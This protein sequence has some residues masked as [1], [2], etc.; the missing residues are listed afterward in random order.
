[1]STSGSEDTE[2]DR[3][4]GRSGLGMELQISRGQKKKKKGL[5]YQ[6]TGLPREESHWKVC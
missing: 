4:R 1:M 3:Y 2:E 6:K 5:L